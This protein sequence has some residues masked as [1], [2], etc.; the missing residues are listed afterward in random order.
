MFSDEE[1]DDIEMRLWGSM[2]LSGAERDATARALYALR[3]ERPSLA[4]HAI[5]CLFPRGCGQCDPYPGTR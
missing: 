2:P 1:L 4:E 3:F 5:P